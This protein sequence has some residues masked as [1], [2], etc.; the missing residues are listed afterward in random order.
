MDNLQTLKDT[1]IYQMI[2]GRAVLPKELVE[3]FMEEAVRLSMEQKVILG[4]M[5][6]NV[7][8]V[9][10]FDSRY[11]DI[12]LST[13]ERVIYP[14]VTTVLGV[15]DKSWLVR[16]LRSIGAEEADER[17]KAA[18]EEGSLVHYVT[19]IIELGHTIIFEHPPWKN[20]DPVLREQNARVVELCKSSAVPYF[21]VRN[22]DVMVQALR[23]ER[24]LDVM[25]PETLAR[26][27]IVVST[28]H[29]YA[30]TLDRLWRVRAGE[31][32]LC[33]SKVVA[34]PKD[35]VAI[36]DIKTGVE[37]DNYAKQEAAY[38]EAVEESTGDQVDYT[39]TVYLD[40][41]TKGENEGIKVVLA[42]REEWKED[43]NLFLHVNTLWWEANE[44]KIPGVK[45]FKSIIYRPLKDSA[46]N[47]GVME[48]LVNEIG[49]SQDGFTSQKRR[50]RDGS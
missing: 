27:K 46:S 23:W 30:G 38:A 19:Q 42:S 40:S 31:Y 21:F 50:K 11:Y 3:R 20:P 18:L 35:G 17:L 22:Q 26:E 8:Q 44:D 43:F 28:R 5:L 4:G 41:K 12:T 14:S 32:P 6:K 39:V 24:V 37:D 34:I 45:K 7:R 29:K 10:Y 15:L 1:I 48:K 33:G 47:G 2:D 49:K 25:N 13:G 16:M 9:S 36:I